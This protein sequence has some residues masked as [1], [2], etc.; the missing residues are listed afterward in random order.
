M[1]AT[2]QSLTFIYA[3]PFDARMRTI[4]ETNG[5]LYPTIEVVKEQIGRVETLWN[6][7]NEKHTILLELSMV[8]KRVPERNLEC[9]VFG[10]GSSSMST[11]FLLAACGRNGELKTD[12]KLI[13]T[14]IHELLH[15]FLVTNNKPYWM[16]VQEQFCNEE[17]AC[18]NHI[19]LY[20]LLY[21]VYQRLFST[22]PMD[23][24]R[25]NLPSGYGRAIELVKEL[26]HKNIIDEYHSF[27]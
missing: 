18:R 11:P 1:P 25:D 14:I 4:T 22:E 26:G 21:D 2:Q 23:F 3:Y 9:F 8:T 13:D 6:E 24:H 10:G 16:S 20:A 7:T 17:P 12:Q 27:V 15:I 19:L 5:E